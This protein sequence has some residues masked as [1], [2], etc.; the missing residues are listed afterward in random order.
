MKNINSAAGPALFWLRSRRRPPFGSQRSGSCCFVAARLSFSPSSGSLMRRPPFKKSTQDQRSFPLSRH[1]RA[2]GRALDALRCGGCGGCS[3]LRSGA[4]KRALTVPA[5]AP[6]RVI[7]AAEPSLSEPEALSSAQLC[8]RGS[9]GQY[10]SCRCRGNGG[11]QCGKGPLMQPDAASP[12]WRARRGRVAADRG[13]GD[14]SARRRRI[15]AAGLL[16]AWR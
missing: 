15:R 8:V 10:H 14:A 13:R 5:V 12:V 9:R 6:P 11:S 16:A 7:D 2:G 4:H 1:Y 3:W